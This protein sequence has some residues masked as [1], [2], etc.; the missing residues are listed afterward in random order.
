MEVD[1]YC[2]FFTTIDP[3]PPKTD[4]FVSLGEIRTMPE[5]RSG[6]RDAESKCDTMSYVVF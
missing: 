5:W 1:L 2:I 6:F 3:V 4:I